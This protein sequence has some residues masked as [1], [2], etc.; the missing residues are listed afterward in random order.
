MIG[1]DKYLA[2]EDGS[3]KESIINS[4]RRSGNEQGT[5]T[6]LEYTYIDPFGPEDEGKPCHVSH[7]TQTI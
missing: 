1:H 7:S 2:G 6:A 5:R 3:G 4:L